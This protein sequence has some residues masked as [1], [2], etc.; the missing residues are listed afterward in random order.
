MKTKFPQ[1]GVFAALAIP[2]D[3]KRRV[4]KRA[5][6]THLAWLRS[7]G[8]AGVLALGSTGDFVRFNVEERKEILEIIAELAGPE[9]TVLAN[10]SDVDIRKTTELGRFARK[11]KLA[12]VGVMPPS[13]FPVLPADQ[14]AFFET[15]AEAAQ[16][17]VM[18]Y[19][20]P[21]LTGNRIAIETIAKFADRQRMGGIKQ[22]GREFEY[23]KEL[24]ALGKEKKFAVFSGADTRL[25]EVFSMGAAGCIGGLV[26]MVPEY[27]VEIFNIVKKGQTGGDLE[28][29]VKRM[30]EVGPIIDQLTFPINVPAGVEARG[31]EPGVLK[32]VISRESEKAYAKIVKELRA[33]FR[34]WKLPLGEFKR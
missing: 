24:I 15:A 18:L 8:V 34:E 1:E 28:T 4:L 22:S 30:K 19:N 23:H 3:A 11:L 33:K 7:K 6:A 27:M 31:F 26:N 12:G 20:F 10:I 2:T 17:P 14:L 5:L 13:F 16:L 25:S 32:T 29:A 9:M 21:E